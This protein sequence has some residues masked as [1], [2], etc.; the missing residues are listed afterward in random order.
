MYVEKSILYFA[1]PGPDNTD[2]LLKAVIRRMREREVKT[3]V[4]AS[5]SGFSVRRFIALGGLQNGHRLVVV[6]NTLGAKFNVRMLYDKYEHT[7]K[8]KEQLQLQGITH[9]PASISEEDER[10]L[11]ERAVVVVRTKDYLGIGGGGPGAVDVEAWRALR[12]KVR[13]FIPLHIRPLDIEAGMD[14]SLL[15]IISMGFRV[16]IGSTVVAVDRKAVSP[17]E[18]VVSVAGTGWAGGGVDTA[19]IVRAAT[20]PKG[21]LVEEIIGFPSQK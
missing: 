11:T 2:T 15:N 8:L 6:T 5:Q 21:C 14:L 12:R 13:P 19:A 16:L 3:C 7:K 17:G 4:I 10:N 9:L 1:V 18:L 20:D